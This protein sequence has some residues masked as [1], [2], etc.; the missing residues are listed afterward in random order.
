VKCPN[1]SSELPA[2]GV[3]PLNFGLRRLQC[4]KCGEWLRMKPL[5][6]LKWSILP[7]VA[8][9]ISL[10]TI[11]LGMF[12]LF[13]C[14]VVGIRVAWAFLAPRIVPL[15]VMRARPITSEPKP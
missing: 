10:A 12:L 7:L 4:G 1:C 14:L 3:L 6:Y 8:L 2:R 15:E 5:L 11:A 9:L 13:V